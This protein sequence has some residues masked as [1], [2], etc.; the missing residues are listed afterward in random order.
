MKVGDIGHLQVRLELNEINDQVEEKKEEEAVQVFRK[1][2]KFVNEQ[3]SD[4]EDQKSLQQSSRL[5]VNLEEIL[6]P[7]TQSF[8]QKAGL[9]DNYLN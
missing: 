7:E 9:L 5:S 4:D 3:S 6:N 2:S 1:D 8:L